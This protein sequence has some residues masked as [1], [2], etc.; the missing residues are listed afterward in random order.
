M[1]TEHI[2]LFGGTFDPV[3]IGHLSLAE[4][5]LNNEV[6]DELWI[7]PSPN[8]P[9]KT[10][11]QITAYEHRYR[12]LELAFADQERVNI[13][14][15]EQRLPQ[16]TYTVQT[17]Q[18]LKQKYPQVQWY[19]CIGEDSLADFESWYKPDKIAEQCKLLVAE[20]PGTKDQIDNRFVKVA[21]YIEHKPVDVSSSDLRKKLAANGK[22]SDMLIPQPVMEYIEEN[23]LYKE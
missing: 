16:P 19:L 12:M 17:I 8:P 9:H 6:L 22:P 7:I 11:K 3:H 18:Y 10:E 21:R 4:S 20:R 15:V 5:F 1:S 14:D 23:N 13:S 2:G